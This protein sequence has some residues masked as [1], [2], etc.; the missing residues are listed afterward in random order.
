MRKKIVAGNWKMNKTYDEGLELAREVN[1]Y[2]RYKE[3]AEGVTVILGTPF[4]HLAKV[5]HNITEANLSVAAQD[6]SAE[7]GGA[8]TGE[9]S[10]A[11]IASTGAKHVIIGHSERR[12]YHG[13]T[14][15]LLAGKV[16]RALEN[17]L[18]IIFCAGEV[19]A[20]RE[21]G[22]HFEVVERQLAEGVFHVTAAGFSRVVIAYEPVWAI[23]TGKTATPDQAQEMHA[24]IRSVVAKQYGDVAA[25]DT[26]ILYGGSCSPANAG[27]LFSRPDVD[28]GLIGGAS[29]KAADF[30]EIIKARAKR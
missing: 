21:A 10:A 14:N 12:A 30:F 26:T 6:C 13:E 3:G 18:G 22:N 15:A 2:L 9:I 4:I 27:E 29:L 8:Y 11:M 1:E 7:K 24:F 17:D 25:A 19:L 20:E 5:A 28:G 23:G 16:N